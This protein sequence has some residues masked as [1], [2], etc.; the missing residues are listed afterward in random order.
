MQLHGRDAVCRRVRYGEVC[1]YESMTVRAE[2]RESEKESS[3]EQDESLKV[4]S[5][6]LPSEQ[7]RDRILCYVSYLAEILF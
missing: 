7:R 3:S 6:I 5:R 4:H 2:E 1:F